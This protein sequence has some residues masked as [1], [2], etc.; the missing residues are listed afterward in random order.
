MKIHTNWFVSITDNNAG[1]WLNWFP[2]SA[3]FEFSNAAF[4]A[5]QARNI[6]TATD[7]YSWF[8]MQ[9]KKKT[10]LDPLSHQLA[11]GCAKRGLRMPLTP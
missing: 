3:Q 10:D 8:K 2:K 1:K 4:S 6:F 9:L 5:T 11:I 7:F